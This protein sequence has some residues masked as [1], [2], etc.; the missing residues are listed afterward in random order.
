MDLS[1][2]KKLK[3]LFTPEKRK[4]RF[5]NNFFYCSKPG[6]RIMDHKITIHQINFVIS[7][8]IAT[9]LTTIPFAIETF[10]V[11]QKKGFKFFI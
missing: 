7:I 9:L 11:T 10:F 5:D 2:F 8:P 4:Y 6:H 1:T 3:K